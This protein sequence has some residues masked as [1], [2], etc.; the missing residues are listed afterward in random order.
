MCQ[1]L[2]VDVFPCCH[3]FQLFSSIKYV[4]LF[5]LL[6][7]LHLD[8]D[9]NKQLFIEFHNSMAH[10]IFY[11]WYSSFLFILCKKVHLSAVCG[12]PWSRYIQVLT[13][14]R[15]DRAGRLQIFQP[16]FT[17]RARTY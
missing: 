2:L 16:H 5:L 12:T 15:A 9:K 11:C 13:S 3:K 7:F 17:L 14:I 1:I 4:S 8:I 10:Y 6:S